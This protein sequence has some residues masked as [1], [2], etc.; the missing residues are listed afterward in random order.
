MTK[1]PK[2]SGFTIVRNAERLGYPFE[3]AVLSVLPLCDEFIINCGDSDD[4]TRALCAQLEVDH[5]GKVKVFDSV[6][7]REKQSGGYQLKHQTDEALRRATGAWCLYIQ[8]DEVMHEADRALIQEAMQD[9][10]ARP[11]I[12]GVLFQYLHFYGNYE[13]EIRGR[14][15]YRREVRLFKNGRGIAAFRDAQG[16]RKPDGSKLLV[17]SS[18]AR[19]FHYGY[20]RSPKSLGVK[21]NQM[22]QWWGGKEPAQAVPVK[23]HV[24]LRRYTKSHP[25]VMR[26]RIQQAQDLVDPTQQKRSWDWTEIKNAVTLAWEYFVPY[27]MGEFR[28]YE[29]G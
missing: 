3:E 18:D 4:S 8:A 15:W 27:R 6:W 28:N 22:A 21:S 16:F 13:Y 17:T 20:V 12:D 7:H 14:N 9:A 23:N 25:Q 2:V 11:D 24:G 10:E 19:V 26:A 29:I 5:P 1:H